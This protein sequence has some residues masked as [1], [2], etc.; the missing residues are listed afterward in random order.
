MTS[1]KN[2]PVKLKIKKN[3]SNWEVIRIDEKEAYSNLKDF[4]DFW[5]I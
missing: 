3:K 1:S 2:I 5:T 4:F